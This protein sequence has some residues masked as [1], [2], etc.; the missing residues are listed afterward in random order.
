MRCA[1]A[2]ALL[3]QSDVLMLD[4]PTNF[5]VHVLLRFSLLFF[6][7]S[8]S[9]QDL[10]AT[11]WLERFLCSREGTLVVTAHD[12]AFLDAI[13]EESVA[14]RFKKLEYFEGTPS[15]WEVQRA[16]EAKRVK[17]QKEALEKQRGH[18]RILIAG[19]YLRIDGFRIDR[20]VDT[21]GQG[22]GE[23]ERRR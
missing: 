7:P 10:E 6:T 11:I 18:V 2:S 13:A 16:K 15:A 17:G 20:E 14:V 1:L 19:G 21:A 4:E 8:L 9:V 5:L 12:I 23:E 3:I 22:C